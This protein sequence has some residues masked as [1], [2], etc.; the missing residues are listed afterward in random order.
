MKVS[1]IAFRKLITLACFASAVVSVGLIAGD[2][3]VCA[4]QLTLTRG[5]ATVFIEPYAPNIVR[6]SLSLRRDDALAAPGYGISA[7]SSPSGWTAEKDKSGDVLR[8]SR[9][10]VTISP[11]GGKWVPSGTQADI[12]K[13]FNG[14]TP[15]VSLSIRT[16]EGSS[17]LQMHGWQM[18]V[19]NHKDGN[20][21][22]LYDRRA[23]DSPFFQV[24]LR[25]RLV[26][27]LDKQT[28]P[29]RPDDYS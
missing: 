20:A 16:P 24:G 18:S 9:M 8:S 17:L 6:V 19:P 13:F 28:R 11:E 14:S 25:R 3:I 21:D 12:A 26:Q 10:V 1:N 5:D 15:G 27:L 23:T 2:K 22:I 7:I 4:Q 29:W